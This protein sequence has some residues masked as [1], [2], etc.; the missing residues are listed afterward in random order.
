MHDTTTRVVAQVHARRMPSHK[1]EHSTRILLRPKRLR[2]AQATPSTSAMLPS[3]LLSQPFP[4]GNTSVSQRRRDSTSNDGP[5]SPRSVD[6]SASEHCFSDAY[7]GLGL[8]N[9]GYLNVIEFTGPFHEQRMR[10]LLYDL[11]GLTSGATRG[12]SSI[13]GQCHQVAGT[14]TLQW[15]RPLSGNESSWREGIGVRH[16]RSFEHRPLKSSS[17]A[18]SAVAKRMQGARWQLQ[19]LR[20]SR[21]PKRLPALL[22]NFDFRHRSQGP[23]R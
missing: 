17:S 22:R 12:S 6:A 13:A 9:S 5:C 1:V 19:G 20:S 2:T 16:G 21:R 3:R 4:A 7:W 18:L 14:S 8:F 23:R 15:R 11:Q 10:I